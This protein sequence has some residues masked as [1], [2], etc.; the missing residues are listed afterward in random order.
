[1]QEDR[2]A[3]VQLQWADKQQQSMVHMQILRRFQNEKGMAEVSAGLMGCWWY[4][5]RRIVLGEMGTDALLSQLTLFGFF[6]LMSD[7]C[8]SLGFIIAPLLYPDIKQ[9][10]LLAHRVW[11]WKLL[12]ENMTTEFWVP[13][14]LYPTTAVCPQCGILWPISFA[15][16]LRVT[17]VDNMRGTKIWICFSR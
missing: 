6:H 7:D 9:L 1:M 11:A 15:G 12:K 2:D 5:L 3:K 4:R 10:C 16:N 17:W 14:G 8:D 13:F